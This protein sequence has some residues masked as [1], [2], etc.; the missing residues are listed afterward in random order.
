MNYA[1]SVAGA[2]VTGLRL[3]RRWVRRDTERLLGWGARATDAQLASGMSVPAD[4]DP[5]FT[6]WMSRYDVL[7]W[8]KKH[9]DHHRAQ[10]TLDTAESARRVHVADASAPDTPGWSAGGGMTLAE[11]DLAE[12]RFEFLVIK[13]LR[14]ERMQSN[15]GSERIPA[16]RGAADEPP[17]LRLRPPGKG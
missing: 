1:G 10:L 3:A 11:L 2:R 5:Y 17:A 14:L 7:V 4:W 12:Q 16:Q 9:Y 13:F 6:P 8:T 15:V